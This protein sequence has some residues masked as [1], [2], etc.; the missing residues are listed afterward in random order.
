[1]ANAVFPKKKD[2]FR[3]L[4]EEAD[5]YIL[6]YTIINDVSARNVQ[7]KHQQWYLGKAESYY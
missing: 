3:I 5:E 7:L 1:V 2:A 6:G 4:P